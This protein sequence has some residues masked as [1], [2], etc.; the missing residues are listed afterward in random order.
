MYYN[1][2]TK[3][4]Y[5]LKSKGLGL[6]IVRNS[7]FN[8]YVEVNRFTYEEG[9]IMVL[10]SDG[11]I[12]ARNTKGEEFGYERL[13]DFLR[14]HAELSVEALEKAL[15]NKLYR[16]CGKEMLDDDYTTMIVRFNKK[17]EEQ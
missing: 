12:E 13:E 11:I 4:S 5:Y 17:R 8:N 7:T 6:G 10:Y 2:K 1:N 9:D 16:F 15:I 3:E 14:S